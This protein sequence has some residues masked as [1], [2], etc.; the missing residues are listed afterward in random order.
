MKIE[1]SRSESSG[2]EVG[3]Y[4]YVV[5]LVAS[6]G[7][8]LFGYDLVIISGA[9]IYL[10]EQ[11]A[12]GDMA[13]G[14]TTTSAIIGCIAGPFLGARLCDWMGRKRTLVLSALLLGV[15]ALVT[16]LAKDMV[17]F[18]VFRIV[19][20]L[21]IGL[22]SIAS[23]IYIAEIAPARVRGRLGVMY[24]VAIGVGAL[25]SGVVA[26]LLAKY[27]AENVSWRWMFASEMVPIIGFVIFL[28]FV[29]RSPRWLAETDCPQEALQV[30]TR[31]GGPDFARKELEEIRES[32]AQE[33]G[34]FS[35]IF[36]PGMRTALLVGVLLAFFNNWTGWTAMGYYLPTLF[37]RGGFPET[38]DAIFQWVI[39][40]SLLLILTLVA[41]WLVDRVGRR[42]LWLVGSLSMVVA[43]AL[44]GVVFHFDLRGTF[45]LVIVLVA[46]APH[47]MALGPLPWLMMSELFPTR[48][49]AGAVAITTTVIWIA[50][51]TA[52]F[53]F[54]ILMAYSERLLGSVGGA[55]WVFSLICVFA[56]VFG[57]RLLPETKGR[58]LE[59]IARSWSK[60]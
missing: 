50:G 45:V 37:Q 30:L 56:F 48:I 43:L 38:A 34:T 55:F 52:P 53:A 22:S 59:E 35:E 17:I 15:S 1:F 26:Y 47:A 11:F 32:L 2:K 24:Q 60:S 12:L 51:F 6:I 21:G 31:I 41:L 23:P 57:L 27:V 42:P 16:A 13:F 3:L 39:V 9:Q 10:R 18:N 29:P 33:S 20:G 19:G 36:Q 40:E 28:F 25:M 14:F 7:G 44:T 4:A 54:P 8:F 49:R 5:S 46:G 58:T